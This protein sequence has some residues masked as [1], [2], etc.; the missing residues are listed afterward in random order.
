MVG[1]YGEV[2]DADEEVAEILGSIQNELEEKEGK[3]FDTFKA[4]SYITQVVAGTNYRIKVSS[5]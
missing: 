5:I 3:E 4:H 2:M 1:A